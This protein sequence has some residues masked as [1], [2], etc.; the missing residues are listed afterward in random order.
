MANLWPL[1]RRRVLDRDKNICR[2]CGSP[3][4]H[5][6]HIHPRAAGGTDHPGNLVAACGSC[7]TRKNCLVF[8]SFEA[9][10]EWLSWTPNCACPPYWL[11]K[12]TKSSTPEGQALAL[13]AQKA[14]YSQ[15]EWRA[16]EASQ[17]R[18][19]AARA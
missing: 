6:D 8:E 5:V 7:N 12:V 14:R 1:T 4:T 19:A 17:L 13:A 16:I 11:H 10:R 18:K 2:Y 9:A 3:A 15:S